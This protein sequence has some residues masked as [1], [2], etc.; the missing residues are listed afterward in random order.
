MKK[1]IFFLTAAVI[2]GKINA[3]P[4][5]SESETIF[6]KGSTIT[7]DK[8]G[9]LDTGLSMENRV[10][11]LVSK[12]TLEEKI[13]QLVNN[14]KEI[15]RLG[16]PEYNWWN[17]GLHGVARAGV[18]TV[19]PQAIGLAATWDV[20]LMFKTSDVISTEARAKY[21]YF[22]KNGE[23]GIYKGLT[24]WSPNINIFRD[25]RWGRGQETYGEDPY[26]TSRMGVAFI[27]GLQGDDPNYFKVIAT[28]KHYA[29][30]SGPEP[31]RHEFDAI[32]DNRDLYETYLPAFEASIKEGGAFSIM[33]AYNRFM[34]EACCGSGKLLKK[35]LRE[36]WGFKGYVVSDCGAIE[37]IY[38]HHKITDSDVEA[39]ALSIKSGTDLCCGKIYSSA[40]IKAVNSGF[41][42]EKEIDISLK[43]LY[44]ARFR[45]GM[46]DPQEK[47]KY[48]T[49]PI[50]ENDSE[51]HRKLSL[52]AAQESIVL[53]KNENNILPLKKDLKRIAVIG[54]TADSY[55]MLLGNYY[56][57]PSRY[58]TP[59]KGIKNKAGKEIEILYEQ[60]CNLVGEGR[61]KN[62]IST[63]SLNAGNGE[64]L[65][66]EYF[67]NKELAGNPFY[68]RR[69]ILINPNWVYGSREPSFP[70]SADF[71]SLRWTGKI[72]PFN[73]GVINFEVESDG[74]YRLYIDN[75][76]IIDDWE[77]VQL[78]VINKS[79]SLEGGKQYNFRLE[80]CLKTPRPQ[81]FVKWEQLNNDNFKNAIED[82]KKSDAIIFVGGITAQ[83]EGEE[84]RVDYEGF[85]GGDR[86]S[87]NLPAIQ[88][89]LL[90]ELKK[91]GK[92]MILVLT[93]GSALSVNWEEENLPAIVQLWY[94]GEEGG[95]ALADV[96]FGDYNPGG[97]LPV[98]FYKSVDQLPAFEDYNMK[99]RTYRF[100]KGEALYPFGYGLSY[101][102][103]A[104]SNL[105]IPDSIKTG[106]VFQV[107]ADVKNT[108]K[109]TGDEVAELYLKGVDLPEGE[110]IQSL[111]GFVRIH[112]GAGEK[113]SVQF[114][115][116]PKQTATFGKEDKFVQE[117][118]GW[119][120]FVGGTQP[121]TKSTTTEYISKKINITGGPVLI[122][123]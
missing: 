79:I 33:C 40:L 34:G 8:P 76:L 65:M 96:L 98:T 55:F 111:Q 109:V 80:Y 114:T 106:E 29:V 46:F 21:N 39:A 51:E 47:V 112:L 84:M 2:I 49:I 16:I 100:F 108:G 101:T 105:K 74:G 66:V 94:P 81:L 71:G 7:G 50:G 70:G 48:S 10:N 69:D 92:P 42:Q 44:M 15:K 73:S 86:T 43:R 32:V 9:Y 27:K 4:I 19:F 17:E 5:I 75:K 97:R 23:R 26:L 31:I 95:N 61:V 25:P 36:D 20:P 116:R 30:H 38:L 118:G 85:K 13:S 28:P 56:G 78:S 14:A 57:T 52:K 90:K 82:A 83:L 121:G 89:R 119:E 58:S 93:S 59:L 67:N 115:V 87:L 22:A 72:T 110:P 37:D 120:I 117:P 113:Q 18:A 3:Q 123:E 68:K 63:E 1:I 41:L 6:K 122:K 104:Y 24:F 11:D 91:T 107:S 62:Y 12:M 35:I 64:G 45:L 54:P 103:F 77:E 88:E 53:L 60:G 99:G 102:S